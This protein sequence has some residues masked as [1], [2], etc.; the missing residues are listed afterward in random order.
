MGV[1]LGLVLLTPIFTAD[2][3]EQGVAAERA[4][5]ALL[6]DARLS[7][8]LKIR[9]GAA[10]AERVELADGRLPDLRPAFQAVDPEPEER[11]ALTRL[12]ARLAGEVERAATQSFSRSFLAGAGLAV[13]VLVALMLPRR[14]GHP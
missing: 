1:V 2:L 4:G 5:S 6:L 13:L 11:R 9:L 8:G 3:E 10:L 14:R 7:P 12:E